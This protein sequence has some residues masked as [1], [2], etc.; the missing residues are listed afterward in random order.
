MSPRWAFNL[1]QAANQVQGLLSQVA[2][3]R[4]VQVEKVAAG[5]ESQRADGIA[6][7]TTATRETFE[8]LL[9]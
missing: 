7:G 6:A 1:V 8:N 2:F 5:V 3:V 9:F 4:Y